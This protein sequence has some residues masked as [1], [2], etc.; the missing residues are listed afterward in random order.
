MQ[1]DLKE[2]IAKHSSRTIPVGYSAADVRDVLQDTWEYLQCDIN[3][4]GTDTSRSDFFG[5]N[6][7]SWCG[8]TATYETSGYDQLVAI[9]EN[10]SIPVF[11]SEYGCNLPAGQPRVFD[12]VQALYGVN[13]TSL[14]GGLVY[15]FSEE[16]DDFGLVVI[17]SN[18]TIN[19]LQDY[20]NL[21]G[22]YDKLNLKLLESTSAASSSSNPPACSSS[23]ISNSSFSSNFTIPATPSGGADLISN[24]I[25][26]APSGTIVTP[27]SLSVA[28][29]VYG[30]NGQLISGLAVKSVS[31]ANT[32]GNATTSSTGAGTTKKGDA[33]RVTPTNGANVAVLAGFAALFAFGML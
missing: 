32:P 24:G 30:V 7:Y 11:F 18:G 26:N 17:A 12:E 13:M 4:D 19:I 3:G 27:S 29:P 31:S 14:S 33:G 20:V 16:P 5:L 6:S 9:F 21:Q 28:Y 8:A 1:R 2:Y 10:S 25:S 22:Q 15:E 23:L